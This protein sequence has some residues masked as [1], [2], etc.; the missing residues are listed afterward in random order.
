MMLHINA[1]PNQGSHILPFNRGSNLHEPQLVSQACKL[2]LG[3]RLRQ[4]ICS[5]LINGDV[6][7]NHFYPLDFITKKINLDLNVFQPVMEHRV[8]LELHTDLIIT[9]YHGRIKHLIKQSR[10]QLTGPHCFRTSITS[11]NIFCFC[12]AKCNK[13]L[14]PASP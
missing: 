10:N 8:L 3:Q 7:E 11:C 5:L 13:L 1:P 12:S 9:I 14:F 2:Y 6:L 4:N